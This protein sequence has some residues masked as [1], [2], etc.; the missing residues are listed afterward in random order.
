MNVTYRWRPEEKL[1][2]ER[3][4]HALIFWGGRRL[5]EEWGRENEWSG[6]RRGSSGGFDHLSCGDQPCNACCTP[7]GMCS[8]EWGGTCQASSGQGS[9]VMTDMCFKRMCLLAAVR[10]DCGGSAGREVETQWQVTAIIQTRWWLGVGCLQGKNWDLTVF[11]VYFE[12]RDR[13]SW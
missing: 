12:S 11:Q 5:V 7:A 6:G 2:R 1:S 3:E 4:Q 10:V 13:I 8:A 9:D